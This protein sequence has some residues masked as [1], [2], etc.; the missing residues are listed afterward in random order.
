M[1]TLLYALIVLVACTVL[2][3][4][5]FVALVLCWPFDRKRRVVHALSKLLTDIIFGLPPHWHRRVVGAE[6]VDR[7]KAYVIVL[8]HNSMVDIACFYCVPLVFKWVSKREV[9]K[10]PFIGRFLLAHGDIII[11]RGSA[12]EAMGKVTERGRMWLSRGASVCIFPEGTRSKDGEIHRFKAGAFLLAKKAG[13]PI[14]PVVLDGTTGLMRGKLRLNWRNTITIPADRGRA[15]A[16]HRYQG[17]DGRRAR[18]HGR[19]IGRDKRG[20]ETIDI[21]QN[22]KTVLRHTTTTR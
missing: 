5:T 8:N 18:R 20:K 1:L 3:A 19:R 14:L 12:S 16:E 7:S 11:D 21:W 2:Y 6:N 13:V 15:S 17:A 9:Y 22:R 10:I 4:L